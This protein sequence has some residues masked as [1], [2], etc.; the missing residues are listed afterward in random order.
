MATAPLDSL[1]KPPLLST[2]MKSCKYIRRKH[3]KQKNHLQKSPNLCYR[4]RLKIFLPAHPVY[5]FRDCVHQQDYVSPTAKPLPVMEQSS[6]GVFICLY[7][8]GSSIYRVNWTGKTNKHK[9]EN[10]TDAVIFAKQNCKE[11]FRLSRGWLQGCRRGQWP[12]SCLS[13]SK[14]CQK[15][16]RENGNLRPLF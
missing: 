3:Q 10:Y 15:V 7:E 8:R 14:P 16:E 12:S 9:K 1:Q 6:G 4:E 5:Y 13:I 2:N 11:D